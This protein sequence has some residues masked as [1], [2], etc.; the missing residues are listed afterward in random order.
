MHVY[1][2]CLINYTLSELHLSFTE[3]PSFMGKPNLMEILRLFFPLRI[4]AE[5]PPGSYRSIQMFPQVIQWTYKLVSN[6]ILSLFFSNKASQLTTPLQV[7]YFGQKTK[8]PSPVQQIFNQSLT[9]TS[10]TPWAVSAAPACLKIFTLRLIRQNAHLFKI[11]THQH[12][13]EGSNVDRSYT[14]AS[15]E[16]IPTNMGAPQGSN[17]SPTFF[18]VILINISSIYPAHLTATADDLTL[19]LPLRIK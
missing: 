10:K 8:N 11:L 16:V 17:V 1:N 13:L 9:T 19:T 14:V 4:Q 3:V 7:K 15:Y 2:P 6:D 5:I 12:N 18:R